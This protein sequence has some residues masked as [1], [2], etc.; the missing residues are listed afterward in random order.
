MLPRNKIPNPKSTNP[1]FLHAF[2]LV[3][4]LVVITIIGIL[5]SLLL[6]AVQSAR[7]AAR[8]LQCS[9][10]LKQLGL[11]ALNHE[12]AMGFFPGGG[13]G[14]QWAG[15]PD[16]GFGGKQPGAWV[17]VSLPFM[18]QQA[19]FDM[20]K[21]GD[22][23]GRSKKATVPLSCLHCP[24]R[25]AAITY[26]FTIQST[27]AYFNITP[28]ATIARCDY[29]GNAGDVYSGSISGPG[30]LE[31]GDSWS[32]STWASQPGG[33]SAST[34]IVH[35]HSQVTMASIRDGTSNT[36][37]A[38][39]RYVNPE[40]YYDG[41]SYDDDQGWDVGLDPDN[42]RWTVNSESYQPMQ[43]RPG[44]TMGGSFGS[45][46]SAGFNMIF[47]DGSVHSISYSI[48]LAIHSYLGNRKDGQ[49]IDGAKF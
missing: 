21:N 42:A 19:L 9:N 12:Q 41:L 14:D 2:T 43:D 46:H 29:A 38:G 30:S 45:A 8:R 26:P 34:G 15:D 49:T 35:I 22:E 37:Y 47:C 44:A 24:S 48:D 25:R 6:P 10:S 39:E 1:K 11:A 28:G 32:A 18:E 23:A 27:Y 3:E 13:W 5:I 40:H 7:E 33:D 16:R 20:G 4:L 31:T 36:Y 17:Y